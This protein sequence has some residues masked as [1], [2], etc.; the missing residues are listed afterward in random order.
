MDS[1][2]AVMP[3]MN[4]SEKDNALRLLIMLTTGT[5][6]EKYYTRSYLDEARRQDNIEG[7][8]FALSRLAEAYFAQWDTDS[9]FIYAEEAIR[10]AQRHKLYVHL[11]D[12][13]NMIIKRYQS[14]GRTLTAL[15]MAE[16]AFVPRFSLC[17]PRL[18]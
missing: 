6:D 17:F 12:M 2:L 14:Q 3:Q 7:E 16:E 10:F 4:D 9:V 5:P 15:R 11:S 8:G 18:L 1:V 13:R